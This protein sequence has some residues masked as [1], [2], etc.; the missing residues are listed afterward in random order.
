MAFGN[1]CLR[2]QGSDRVAAAS[3]TLSTPPSATASGRA[4]TMPTY[5][6]QRLVASDARS[7]GTAA[8]GA[9][10][11]VSSNTMAVGVL[12]ATING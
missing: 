8:F 2:P 11:A 9:D 4:D 3:S 10:S 5:V 7:A 12:A 1:A 6:E